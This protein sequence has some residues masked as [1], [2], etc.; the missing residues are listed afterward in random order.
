MS[1][2]NFLPLFDVFSGL[3]RCWHIYW[4]G[5]SRLCNG[6][7]F[8]LMLLSIVWLGI[9]IIIDISRSFSTKHLLASLGTYHLALTEVGVLRSGMMIKSCGSILCRVM[10]S[11]WLPR[12]P[13]CSSQDLLAFL[14]LSCNESQNPIVHDFLFTVQ[15]ICTWYSSLSKSLLSMKNESLFP[16]R[17]HEKYSLHLAD[18]HISN[19]QGV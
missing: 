4:S 19:R 1:R 5:N 14:I 6:C 18:V 12:L 11:S 15:R 3:N 7:N 9:C 16:L 8:A 10:I 2:M 17:W 13:R